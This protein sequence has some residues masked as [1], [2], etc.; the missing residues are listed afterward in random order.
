MSR[1]DSR[2]AIPVQDQVL[3]LLRE[4]GFSRSSI[5]ETAV[6]MGGLNAGTVAEYFR[7]ECLKAFA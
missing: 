7:G 1:R 2:N 3:E 6:E 4:K 5:S